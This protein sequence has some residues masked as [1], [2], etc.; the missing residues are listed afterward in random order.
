MT[1]IDPLAYAAEDRSAHEVAES[2]KRSAREARDRAVQLD[3]QAKD[4]H[5]QAEYL[6]A[7]MAVRARRRVNGAE[8]TDGDRWPTKATHLQRAAN[9]VLD[10]AGGASDVPSV[11]ATGGKRPVSR[12]DS[13]AK[14]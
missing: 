2:A 13:S 1:L 7:R 5:A 9:P 3:A 8:G 6:F 11:T 14:L 4:L 12:V 10:G